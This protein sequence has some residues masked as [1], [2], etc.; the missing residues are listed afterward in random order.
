ML[1]YH[2]TSRRIDSRG[3]EA[4]AK[5][6]RIVLDTDMSGRQDAFNPA[7]MLLTMEGLRAERP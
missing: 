3:G 7:E 2:V 1:D 4:S 5:D 6:A